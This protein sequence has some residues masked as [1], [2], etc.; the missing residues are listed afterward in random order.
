[1]YVNRLIIRIKMNDDV[2]FIHVICSKIM[3]R[4]VTYITEILSD[5]PVLL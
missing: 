5:I 4:D 2:N 3:V 1:M